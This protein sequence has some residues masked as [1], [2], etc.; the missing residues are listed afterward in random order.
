MSDQHPN[1]PHQPPSGP[2]GPMSPEEIEAA[3]AANEAAN[4]LTKQAADIK[5]ACSGRGGRRVGSHRAGEAGQPFETRDQAGKSG[6]ARAADQ[7][8]DDIAHLPEIDALHCLTSTRAADCAE[9]QLND[10]SYNIHGDDP[11]SRDALT[12]PHATTICLF[13]VLG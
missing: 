7:A 13:I 6:K 2:T 11:L 12:P 3:Q 8:G 4:A 9:N 10:Q 5:A 1:H